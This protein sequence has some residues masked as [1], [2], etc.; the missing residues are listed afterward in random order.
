MLS[1]VILIFKIQLTYSYFYSAV[2]RTNFVK[3]NLQMDHQKKLNARAKRTIAERER[4]R[5]NNSMMTQFEIEESRIRKAAA[6]RERKQSKERAMSQTDLDALRQPRAIAKRVQRNLNKLRKSTES[7]ITIRSQVDE[8]L[9]LNIE[10]S[11]VLQQAQQQVN[12]NLPIINYRARSLLQNNSVSTEQAR[13]L[14]KVPATHCLFRSS[15]IELFD[16]S[17]QVVITHR[18]D[19]LLYFMTIILI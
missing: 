14:R 13:L 17:R 2:K 15:T 8:R 6:E 11:T 4:K 9:L 19:I 1:L 3:F 10:Q 7:S 12:A 16:I 5:R 18:Y